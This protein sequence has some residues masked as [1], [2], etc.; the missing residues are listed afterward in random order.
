M[1]NMLI[2][3]FKD[4]THMKN[5]TQSPSSLLQMSPGF[6][7]WQNRSLFY[8]TAR[9]VAEKVG[10]KMAGSVSSNRDKC[11]S[12]LGMRADCFA[13][14]QI[15]TLAVNLAMKMQFLHKVTDFWNR[16]CVLDKGEKQK[17]SS[18]LPDC[19][20]HGLQISRK[21]EKVEYFRESCKYFCFFSTPQLK[22]QIFLFWREHR[23]AWRA[24]RSFYC[25][26]RSQ[27]AGWF[28]L[29]KIAVKLKTIH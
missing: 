4:V 9:L 14:Y 28:F 15:G 21:W 29:T 22:F 25:F 18:F 2:L 27:L 12:M 26:F 16:Y 24:V 17:K 23:N 6:T 11:L 19:L 10:L 13:N 20:A 8:V 5:T 1:Q 7:D 3:P